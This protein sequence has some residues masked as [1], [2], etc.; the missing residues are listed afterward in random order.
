MMEENN[1]DRLF[2]EKLK[3]FEVTP[4]PKVWNAIEQ[5]LQKKKRRVLPI[6][7]IS[8]G[9]AASILLGV[10]LFWNSQSS[11]ESI[12]IE[13]QNN[14][15]P[16]IVN[17]EESSSEE[18]IIEKPFKV[19][20]QEV[21]E[22]K[23]NNT[24]KEEDLSDFKIQSKQVVY[25]KEIAETTITQLEIV[26]NTVPSKKETQNSNINNS[27]SEFNKTD[28]AKLS[29]ET[30]KKETTRDDKNY[31]LEQTENVAKNVT[32]ETYKK[33]FAKVIAQ[34]NNEEI[35]IEKETQKKWNISPVFGILKSESFTN[36][37]AIDNSINGKNSGKNTIAYGVNVEYAINDKWAFKSGLQLQKSNFGYSEFST[38]TNNDFVAFSNVEIVRDNVEFSNNPS[39]DVNNDSDIVTN[40]G[41]RSEI[42]N[43][44]HNYT[45]IEIPL[46]AKYTFFKSGFLQTS[47][48]SGFSTLL[49]ANNQL[50]W[51]TSNFEEQGELTNLNPINF[52]GNLGF[53]FN[54]SINKNSSVNVTPM[55]KT[56][57][58]TFSDN[59]TDFKPYII[60]LYTGFKY[61]F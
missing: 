56:Q 16:V 4:N 24:Q 33:D 59:T 39:D 44:T 19:K 18:K 48:V 13:N 17:G 3:D 11:D 61:Q 37:S 42:E 54:F 29:E 35:E 23:K 50:N 43:I 60:A 40:E 26:E 25:P 7:W 31:A 30:L 22:V 12:E 52:S 9:T 55:F 45:Y 20:I 15:F 5:K 14:S 49:L 28:V 58:N 1:L 51:S 36:S 47:L 32:Q 27:N 34:Q 46:E 41:N 2:Q 6:W 57:L 38:I 53:D 10:F 8:G 21:V